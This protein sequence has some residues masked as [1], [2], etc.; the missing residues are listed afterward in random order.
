MNAKADAN[1]RHVRSHSHPASAGWHREAKEAE[2]RLNGFQIK[3]RCQSTWLKPGVNERRV[4]TFEA[5]LS[6]RVFAAIILVALVAFGVD[7][8]SRV[9]IDHNTGKTAN[10]EFKFSRIPSPSRN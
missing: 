2:N 4:K 9:T 5:Q 10:A 3:Q 1:G 6:S 7:A 8:Q